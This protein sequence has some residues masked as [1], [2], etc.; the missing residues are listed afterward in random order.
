[1]E[2]QNLIMFGIVI[3]SLAIPILFFK[4]DMKNIV[5]GIYIEK[6][7]K[8]LKLCLEFTLPTN[9][10]GERE[11]KLDKIMN[12]INDSVDYAFIDHKELDM[13]II[14][15]L[16]SKDDLFY[17]ARLELHKLAGKL[18]NDLVKECVISKYY[19]KNLGL[20]N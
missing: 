3:L 2:Y 15:A 9:S 5:N 17:D 1:M 20:K 11:I 6:T 16:Q 13:L 8:K 18:V 14:S 4:H 12:I 7:Y 10:F 19:R